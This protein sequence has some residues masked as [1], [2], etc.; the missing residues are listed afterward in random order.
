MHAQKFYEEDQTR[1]CRMVRQESCVLML[2]LYLSHVWMNGSNT[3]RA[4]HCV[5]KIA[6][7]EGHDLLSTGVNRS[8]QHV[9]YSRHASYTTVKFPIPVP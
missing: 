4:Q 8:R 5:R 7:V 9:G 1:T 6:Q 3:V 2:S